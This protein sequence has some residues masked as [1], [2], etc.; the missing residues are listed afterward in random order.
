MRSA[1]HHTCLVISII[2][3]C[4]FYPML[5][6]NAEAFLSPLKM[7]QWLV[8]RALS[9]ASSG[10]RC[11]S[12]KKK[13]TERSSLL[14]L[15]W[16]FRS[17]LSALVHE[18]MDIPN[19]SVPNLCPR[20]S[21]SPGHLS[22]H[23]TPFITATVIFIRLRV[24]RTNSVISTRGPTTEKHTPNQAGRC[25]PDVACLHVVLCCPRPHLMQYK[26]QAARR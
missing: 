20:D 22:F 18:R 10:F 1:R 4:F 19:H 17:F 26:Y 16:T 9:G 3:L 23:R 2:H 24:L 8:I 5:F 25:G 15:Q 11:R 13:K 21:P 12:K 14:R 6:T 7:I